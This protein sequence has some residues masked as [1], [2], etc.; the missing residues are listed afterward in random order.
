MEAY[1]SQSQQQTDFGRNSGNIEKG[2][3]SQNNT[4]QQ[5]QPGVLK[6]FIYSRGEGW[7]KLSCDQSKKSKQLHSLQALQNETFTQLDTP[8]S[9]KEFYLQDN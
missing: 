9:R 3:S 7:R 1:F 8:P 6:Q 2:Y 4:K 5:Q